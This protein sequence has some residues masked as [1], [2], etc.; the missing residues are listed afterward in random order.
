VRFL[1]EERGVDAAEDD[2]RTTFAR[3][4]ADFVPANG[5][6]AVDPVP[7]DIAG[8]VPGPQANPWGDEE[9]PDDT[10]QEDNGQ[11]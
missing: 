8:I 6:A 11:A 7:H 10:D 4:P 2:V 3:E 1:G 5:I 9:A